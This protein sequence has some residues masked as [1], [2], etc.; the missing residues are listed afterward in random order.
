M[1]IPLSGHS[2]RAFLRAALFLS[3]VCS[4]SLTPS[5]NVGAPRVP[6][7]CTSQPT[8]SLGNFTHAWPVSEHAVVLTTHRC[9]F[10]A[11]ISPLCPGQE[12]SSLASTT[13][14]PADWFLFLPCTPRFHAAATVS[15]L[16]A[17]PQLKMLLP[18]WLPPA[19]RAKPKLLA[20]AEKAPHDPATTYVYGLSSLH[21]SSL[22]YS[23]WFMN[24][25]DNVHNICVREQIYK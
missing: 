6:T 7:A 8:V 11:W 21:G 14:Q 18:L 13:G 23:L 12:S 20:M 4:S 16:H 25:F 24:M 17:N 15:P 22:C 5:L 2:Q 1:S 3:D 19:F 9:T 10:P